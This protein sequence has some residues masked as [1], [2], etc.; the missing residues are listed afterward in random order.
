[1]NRFERF[2]IILPLLFVLSMSMSYAA[3]YKLGVVNA[4]KILEASPQADAARKKLEKEFATRDR[5]LVVHSLYWMEIVTMLI[6]LYSQE[7]QS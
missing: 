6:I 3:D 4:P 7:L 2:S 1:M 5:D